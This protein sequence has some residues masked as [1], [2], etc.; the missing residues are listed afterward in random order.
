M[1]LC[2]FRF[3][4]LFSILV[5]RF[6]GSRLSSIHRVSCIIMRRISFRCMVYTSYF[7]MVSSEQYCVTPK[8]LDRCQ[9]T[10]ERKGRE[11]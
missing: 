11:S 9:M 1:I 7:D 10:K 8:G 5:M 2:P 3:A 4:S 6:L